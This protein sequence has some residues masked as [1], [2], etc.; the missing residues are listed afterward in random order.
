MV[1]S[2]LEK[3]EGNAMLFTISLVLVCIIILLALFDLCRIYIARETIKT[4]SDSIA[5]AVSQELLYFRSENITDLAED[6]ASSKGCRL[7]GLHVGYDGVE[8]KVERQIGVSVLGKIG[9]G[10]IKT[11]SSRSRAEVIYPWDRRWGKCRYYE[12]GYKPY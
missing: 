11:I 7:I 9:L 6:I 12:F 4:V 10:S 5:L 1:I 2:R 3:Q 8:V